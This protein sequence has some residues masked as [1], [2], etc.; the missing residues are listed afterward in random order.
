MGLTNINI[1][2]LERWASS[3]HMVHITLKKKMAVIKDHHQT[4][5][6]LLIFIAI[7]LHDRPLSLSFL[8]PHV[9]FIE[10]HG[11]DHCAGWISFIWPLLWPLQKFWIPWATEN[12]KSQFICNSLKN[13]ERGH[14]GQN[15]Q[16]P[17]GD[18]ASRT[19][20]ALFVFSKEL[21]R[22]KW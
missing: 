8:H 20:C 3:S 13:E 17:A 2:I 5:V 1:L 6:Q 7:S 16:C 10:S 15:C 9:W 18:M 22:D 11:I 12:C 14:F 4:I 19:Q 21:K